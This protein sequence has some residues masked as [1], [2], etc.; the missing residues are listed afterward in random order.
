MSFIDFI[1]TKCLL[2][3]SKI[4]KNLFVLSNK[5]VLEGISKLGLENIQKSSIFNKTI[6]ESDNFFDTVIIPYQ[7]ESS[8]LNNITKGTILKEA[9]RIVKEKGAV[10]IHG[11]TE[12]PTVEHGLLNIFIKWVKDFYSDLKTYSEEEFN[13]ELLKAGARDVD[14]FVFRG[15]LFGIGRK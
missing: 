2:I 12:L 14:V 6:R 3:L 10:I 11:Y 7:I 8:D 1:N 5:E 13:E 4:S 15:H 9:F